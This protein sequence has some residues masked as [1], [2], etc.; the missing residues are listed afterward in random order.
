[1]RD[2]LLEE[3]QIKAKEGLPMQVTAEDL[4]EIAAEL[5]PAEELPAAPAEGPTELKGPLPDSFPG[6]T[7]L[8]AADINTYAQVRKQQASAEGLKGVTGIGDVTAEEIEDA[9]KGK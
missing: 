1:M 7:A 8:E 2:E 3:I 9:L 5:K 4:K 6:R